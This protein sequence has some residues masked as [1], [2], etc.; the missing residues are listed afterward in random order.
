MNAGLKMREKKKKKR[1]G[2]KSPKSSLL[3]P[4]TRTGSD[5]MPGLGSVLAACR[6]PYSAGMLWGTRGW[7]ASPAMWGPCF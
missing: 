6:V 5:G 2:K 7:G 3:G 4:V 1:E